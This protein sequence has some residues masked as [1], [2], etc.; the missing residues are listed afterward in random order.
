MKTNDKALSH[1]RVIVG[2]LSVS[3]KWQ[4]AL[5]FSNLCSKKGNK[6]ASCTLCIVKINGTK[7][8]K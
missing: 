2:A 7:V 4:A 6:A 1:A 3:W 5:I 8:Q